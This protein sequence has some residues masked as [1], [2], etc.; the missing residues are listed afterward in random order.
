MLYIGAMYI[1]KQSVL[2]FVKYFSQGSII[3]KYKVPLFFS[4]VKCL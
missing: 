3:E 1:T 2:L 4:L